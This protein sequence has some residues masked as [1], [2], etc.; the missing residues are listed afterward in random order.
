MSVDKDLVSVQQARDLVEAAHRAQAQVAE[1]VVLLVAEAWVEAVLDLVAEARQAPQE[2]LHEAADVDVAD[3]GVVDVRPRQ[4]AVD[5]AGL[6]LQ[7]RVALPVDDVQ[8]D[9]HACSLRTTSRP[10]TTA[11]ATASSTRNGSSGGVG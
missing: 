11:P 2:P 10:A 5:V 6:C 8:D 3:A 9:L 7:R 1:G 4:A